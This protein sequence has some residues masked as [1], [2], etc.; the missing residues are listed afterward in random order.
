MNAICEPGDIVPC[1]KWFRSA[2]LR[3]RSAHASLGCAGP[4]VS[5]V[6]I[7]FI[8]ENGGGPGVRLRKRQKK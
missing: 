5:S 3:R 2:K 4:D 6:G 7:E 8:E 1:S